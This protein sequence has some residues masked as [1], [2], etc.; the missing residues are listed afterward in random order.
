MALAQK[1]GSHLLHLITASCAATLVTRLQPLQLNSKCRA[2][3]MAILATRK[4]ALIGAWFDKPSMMSVHGGFYHSRLIRVVRGHQCGSIQT[5]HPV[6]NKL[7]KEW[8]TT[9]CNVSLEARHA[10][11]Q[12][13]LTRNGSQQ[14]WR[15]TRSPQKHLFTRKLVR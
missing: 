4:G 12:P 7:Q 14:K 15:V 11:G 9:P 13:H 10:A 2:M 1:A 5:E 8:K 3:Y 6:P